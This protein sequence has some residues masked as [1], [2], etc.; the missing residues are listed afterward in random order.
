MDSRENDVFGTCGGVELLVG[1][2][3]RLPRNAS[4]FGGSGPFPGCGFNR[5]HR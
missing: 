2:R 1:R 4:V 3:D 5:W